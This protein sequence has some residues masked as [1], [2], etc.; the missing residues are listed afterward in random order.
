MRAQAHRLAA[1]GIRHACQVAL[2]GIQVEDERGRIDR[3]E[4]HADGGWG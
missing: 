3:S 1:H 4:R 2:E